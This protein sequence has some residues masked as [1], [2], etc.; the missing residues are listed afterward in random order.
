MKKKKES[1]QTHTKETL[2]LPFV[3]MNSLGLHDI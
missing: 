3:R 2:F 1:T